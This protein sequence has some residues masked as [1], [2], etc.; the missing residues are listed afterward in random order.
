M[1]NSARAPPELRSLT[2]VQLTIKPQSFKH[3]SPLRP[4][5]GS[6]SASSSDNLL[7][8]IPACPPPVSRTNLNPP[9]FKRRCPILYSHYSPKL[10]TTLP[11][12]LLPPTTHPSLQLAKLCSS[13]AAVEA[14]AKESPPHSSKQ[15]PKPS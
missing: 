12:M 15:A 10:S 9:K 8:K 1:R 7:Y 11:T 2:M 6:S 5:Q 4:P 3:D 14:L 13:L